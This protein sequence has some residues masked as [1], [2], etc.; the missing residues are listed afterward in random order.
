MHTQF[1]CK[2]VR[3]S[4]ATRLRGFTLVELLVVIGIIAALIGIL[5]PS[6]AS[7]R[8]SA[9]RL[10][11][12]ANM[13][14]IG[15]A[16]VMYANDN[17]GRLPTSTHSTLDLESTWI[18]TLAKYL[19]NVDKVRI[20]PGDP[21][22]AERIENQGTSYVLNE[23]MV[24]ERSSANP[25]D[26]DALNLFKIRRSP[27]AF[28]LFTTSDKKGTSTSDDHT[29]SRG[30]FRAPWTAC[31]TR[32]AADI[33][34]GRFG[35]KNFDST[36]GSSNYLFA[37]GHVDVITAKELKSRVDRIVAAQDPKRNFA[38]PPQ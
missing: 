11:C 8:S 28:L 6:L 23:Y 21:K 27:E 7:A 9:S 16:L 26:V 25:N 2:Y 36:A 1:P 18:Y 35:G 20:S 15:K 30:W 3:V 24:V 29:H 13:R 22:S 34:V 14:E 5:L 12:A 38:R 32:V 10:A 4:S 33:C 37:D 31:W 19:G 17:H